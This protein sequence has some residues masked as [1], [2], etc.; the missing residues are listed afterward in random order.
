MIVR[1]VRPK[2]AVFNSTIFHIEL[3]NGISNSIAKNGDKTVEHQ[4]LHI[5]DLHCS[6]HHRDEQKIVTDAFLNDLRSISDQGIQP[7]ILIF[8]GDIVKSADDDN[9]YLTAAECVQAALDVFSLS[10]N[11]AIFC[12][13]NHDASR[14]F[15]DD[16]RDFL[17]NVRESAKS[18]HAAN[19]VANDS[20]LASYVQSAFANYE[21][22]NSMFARNLRTYHDTFAET[23]LLP[24]QKLSIIS[25]NTA[26]LTGAGI[27]RIEDAGNLAIFEHP[28][29]HALDELPEDYPIIMVGHHPT[30]W[31]NEHSKRTL[32][33]IISNRCSLYLHGHMHDA[34]PKHVRS[35][36]GSCFFAQ[37]G[38]LFSDREYYNG[39]SI[40]GHTGHPEKTKIRFRSYYDKR[41]EFGEGEDQI[42][43]GIFY[44]SEEAEVY[45]RQ[46]A[47]G[48]KM[49]A[50]GKS[51][52][53]PLYEQ[54]CNE[55]L[56]DKSLSKVF[57]DPEFER[58]IG[59]LPTSTIK[60]GTDR[61]IL[62][63]DDVFRSA[64][65]YV[66]SASPESGKTS[67]L[68]KWALRLAE[69]VV[70]GE[71]DIV[72]AYMSFSTAPEYKAKYTSTLNKLVPNLPDG[73]SATDLAKA[74]K[75]CFLIDDVDF[76]HKANLERLGEFIGAFPNCRYILTTATQLLLSAA[77][78]PMV[79][80]VVDFS[81]IDLSPI[82]TSQ[83]RKLIE[84]HDIDQQFDP[85][86][87]ID[88]MYTEMT[89]LSV[90]LTAVNSTF[91]IQIYQNSDNNTIIN[92]AKLVE[93]FIEILL[94]KLA[95]QDLL[96]GSFDFENKI[97]LL[98]VISEMM[99]MEE[100]YSVEEH[101]VLE[102]ISGYMKEFG[103]PYV[104][105]RVLDY[106]I[107]SRVLKREEGRIEFKLRAFFEFH[108]ATRMANST[109]FRDHILDE[110]RYLSFANEI[111]FYSALKRDDDEL[112][113]RIYGR[114]KETFSLD[115]AES[116]IE[117][118]LDAR[119]LQDLKLPKVE[120]SEEELY[121]IEDQLFH[122]R[123]TE[124]ERDALI[125]NEVDSERM[126]DQ[127]I[128]REIDNS[129]SARSIAILILL[130]SVIKHSELVSDEKKRQ[131]VRNLL[132]GWNEFTLL[133][134]AL[135]P[136]M[137]SKQRYWFGGIEYRLNFPDGMETDEIARRLFLAMPIS[138]ARM[139]YYNLGTEKL[140]LQL[141]EGIGSDAEPLERQLI[142]YCIMA[143]LSPPNSGALAE[144]ITRAMHENRFLS[145]VLMLKLHDLLVKLRVPEAERPKV[146]ECIADLVIN[147]IPAKGRP[148][149]RK[150]QIILDYQRQD[151]RLEYK[152]R[153]SERKGNE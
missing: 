37:A 53:L 151:L 20:K 125:D 49:C 66:I 27:A 74:G 56:S 95:M 75:L 59:A 92:K 135:V 26:L 90:P 115:D 30:S 52:L 38:A 126:N 107:S 32:E 3:R 72:P 15:V 78:Q 93:R 140:K 94:D 17:A 102:W 106:F 87:L 97:H 1:S 82:K 13:G 147:L 2:N 18:R 116:E 33:Q 139:A 145:S 10:E 58:E 121:D 83:L 148:G 25:I 111:S 9:D 96:P 7:G 70:A 88:R 45:W 68:L 28:I 76:R 71:S 81:L 35:L 119:K 61:E 47:A 150:T 46:Q 122:R 12:A 100:C 144:T 137:A 120:A 16:N 127:E 117:R 31:L 23:Y 5:S 8:T 153:Q 114:F 84:L 44:A 50:W 24:E 108:C 104:P 136:S 101:K 54:Q 64:D 21:E 41:Q 152:R 48:S 63:F 40:I 133:S 62:T 129:R 22:F 67:L 130:S 128:R 4:I 142:R 134:L 85:D 19:A 80:E 11:C 105:R 89:N 42:G 113:D 51:V 131:V 36:S 73:F 57:V 79:G 39:Y 55:S 14:S 109:E 143:D 6:E 103:L 99:V 146:R 29:R 149:N 118:G 86:T 43:G 98:G 110:C 65:N 60:L 69:D 77:F 123:L 91:L 141:E 138:V 34:Q 124:A 132:D 112:I